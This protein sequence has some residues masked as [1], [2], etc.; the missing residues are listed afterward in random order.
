MY[1]QGI[2]I[3]RLLLDTAVVI[4]GR[5]LLESHSCPTSIFQLQVSK[6]HVQIGIL[7]QRI[8]P[9]SSFAQRS[10]SL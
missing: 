4:H 5:S 10:S 8:L 1:T 6:S 7:S 2:V 3:E 9:G